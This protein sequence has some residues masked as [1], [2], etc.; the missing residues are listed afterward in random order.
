MGAIQGNK[1]IPS[2]LSGG[3]T[4]DLHPGETPIEVIP[5]LALLI[6]YSVFESNRF[7]GIIESRGAVP[8]FPRQANDR[9]KRCPG[10]L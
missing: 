4:A 3:K 9:I 8:I 1:P 5:K 10:P 2:R 6:A 7:P